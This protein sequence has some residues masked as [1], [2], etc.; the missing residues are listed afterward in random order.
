M[1]EWQQLDKYNIIIIHVVK[2]NGITVSNN[3]HRLFS[4][5]KD[6]VYKL[7]VQMKILLLFIMCWGKCG[8]IFIDLLNFGLFI[9]C[10][11][12]GNSDFFHNLISSQASVWFNSVITEGPCPIGYC[13]INVI[14]MRYVLGELHLK[15]LISL[16]LGKQSVCFPREGENPLWK[17]RGYS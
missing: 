3:C 16:V 6:I 15:G 1:K 14:F 12:Q 13:T 10:K 11:L 8:L 7:D 2:S 9:T 4:F 5:S 17:D